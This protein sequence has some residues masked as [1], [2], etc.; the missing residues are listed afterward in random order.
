[1]P[2]IDLHDSR[3]WQIALDNLEQMQPR[4]LAELLKTPQKLQELLRQR[5]IGHFQTLAR[6]RE[7]S[8]EATDRELTDLIMEEHLAPV[9]PDWQDQQPLTKAE[10]AQLEKFAN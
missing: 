2:T 1:M 3:E 4:A 8:P 7:R 5:V 9:N 10:K 6:L